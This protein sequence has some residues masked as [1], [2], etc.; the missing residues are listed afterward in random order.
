MAS[1]QGQGRMDTCF[2][3]YPTYIIWK[4]ENEYKTVKKSKSHMIQMCIILAPDA[5][6]GAKWASRQD[7]LISRVEDM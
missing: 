5:Q 6:N 3:G 7:G 4:A 2:V 1:E